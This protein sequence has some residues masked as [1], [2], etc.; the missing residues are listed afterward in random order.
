MSDNKEKPEHTGKGEVPEADKPK[1]KKSGSSGVNTTRHKKKAMIA[2]LT[3]SLGIV[4]SAAD[5][6]GIGRATHYDWMNNDPKYKAEVEA[7]SE[8]A[9]DFAETSLLTQ[10][11]EKQAAATIFYL[12]TK[13]KSRGYIETHVN[14]NKDVADLGDFTDEEL[15]LIARE[16]HAGF[17]KVSADRKGEA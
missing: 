7:I 16:G 10:I 4:S 2:A 14:I 15:D 5:S 3:S 11:K 9:I 1:K 13:G 6:V 17:K 12:K 8:R